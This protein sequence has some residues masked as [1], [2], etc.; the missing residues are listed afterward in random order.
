[1]ASQK[2]IGMPDGPR[3]LYYAPAF[4]KALELTMQS[5]ILGSAAS[6]NVGPSQQ[7]QILGALHHNCVPHYREIFA[8]AHDKETEADRSK[9]WSNFN[10]ALRKMCF[11]VYVGPSLPAYFIH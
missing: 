5:W 4:K 11:G 7:K 2:P 3:S 1:M 8:L 10:D 6:G 9:R